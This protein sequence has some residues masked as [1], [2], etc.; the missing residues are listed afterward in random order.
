M[1]EKEDGGKVKLQGVD[2]SGLSVMERVVER[3]SQC[4]NGEVICEVLVKI[5]HA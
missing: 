2:E 1:N 4:R 3:R 5:Q